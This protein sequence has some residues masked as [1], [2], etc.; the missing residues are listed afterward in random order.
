MKTWNWGE[1]GKERESNTPIIAGGL[2]YKQY[3]DRVEYLLN[4]AVYFT[5][6]AM[7]WTMNKAKEDNKGTPN[8]D[9][10]AKMQFSQKYP[11]KII[12]IYSNE[13]L[14]N[15]EES[16]E[17]RNAY[18]NAQIFLLAAMLTPIY[19]VIVIPSIC[20][21]VFEKPAFMVLI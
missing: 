8:A 18:K 21:I 19:A 14:D 20:Y 11:D 13:K 4:T 1:P 2:T 5:A 10:W 3:Y 12:P 7:K 17:V 9:Q 16:K 6:A 15:S